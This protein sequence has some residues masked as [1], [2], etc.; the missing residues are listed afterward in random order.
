MFRIMLVS[1]LTLIVISGCATR[2]EGITAQNVSHEK[3]MGLDCG[4]LVTALVD[5]RYKL[6]E[7]SDKQDT[8]ANVDAGGVFLALVPVSAFTG[9]H[10]ADVAQWKG[11]V[12][13]IETAQTIK[14][15][16]SL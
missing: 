2:P 13:A 6:D 11:E 3:Y 4:Q 12:Q 1:A 15:C 14:K 10:E 16:K 5:A 8:K 7:F 9:D